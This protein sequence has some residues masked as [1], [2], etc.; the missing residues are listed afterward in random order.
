[1]TMPLKTPRIEQE[2]ARPK[3]I[4]LR[5]SH[6]A[7]APANEVI[8]RDE[9][10]RREQREQ[11]VRMRHQHP[12]RGEKLRRGHIQRCRHRRHAESEFAARENVEHQQRQ[13]AGDEADDVLSL[14]RW[15][16]VNHAWMKYGSRV[17]EMSSRQANGL[18]VFARHCVMA[19]S[20]PSSHVGEIDAIRYRCRNANAAKSSTNAALAT[21]RDITTPGTAP[22]PKSPPTESRR[23]SSAGREPSDRSATHRASVSIR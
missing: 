20:V 3:A 12:P 11:N 19:M 16:N 23:R 4:A 18:C 10:R 7:T 14:D 1:M 15:R 17:C 22:T 6:F 5:I 8:K 2:V 9:R 13:R 21:R